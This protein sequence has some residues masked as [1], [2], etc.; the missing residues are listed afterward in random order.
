M[1]TEASKLL[2]KKDCTVQTQESK[3]FVPKVFHCCKTK[4]PQRHTKNNSTVCAPVQHVGDPGQNTWA[5]TINE[6]VN[7]SLRVKEI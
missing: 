7:V 6:C 4:E 1:G 3:R 5:F 2:K